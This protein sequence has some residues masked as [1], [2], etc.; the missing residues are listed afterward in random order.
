VRNI[1]VLPQAFSTNTTLRQLRAYISNHLFWSTADE[2]DHQTDECNCSLAR[3]ILSGDL[4]KLPASRGPRIVVL[5]SR[6]VVDIISNVNS[7][8][9][10]SVLNQVRP[11]FSGG[12]FLSYF[13]PAPAASNGVDSGFAI[14]SVCS[15]TRHDGTIGETEDCF[16][17][18]GDT[19][20]V[21]GHGEAGSTARV[22]D[23]HTTFCPIMCRDVDKTI[24]ELKLHELAVDGVL[25]LFV[26]PRNSGGERAGRAAG[27][28]EIYLD[29]KCWASFHSE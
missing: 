29:Q 6:S 23:L 27:Q 15:A 8:D 9:Q 1:P 10:A 2:P 13:S 19:G 24:H 7:L 12:K 22:V 25:A 21:Y 17:D 4:V 16:S 3:A 28:E 11:T 18:D 5:H 20:S 14:V 26:V